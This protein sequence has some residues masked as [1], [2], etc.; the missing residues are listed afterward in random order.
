MNR[1]LTSEV[2]KAA[3]ER[4][5]IKIAVTKLS[6]QA[7]LSESS[8]RAWFRGDD[9]SEETDASITNALGIRKSA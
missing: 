5:F 2:V 6:H 7:N 1:R 9:V 4:G 3:H 8:V